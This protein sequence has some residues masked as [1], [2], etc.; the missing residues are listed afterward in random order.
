M[1]EAEVEVVMRSTSSVGKAAFDAA[2]EDT[3]AADAAAARLQ[4]VARGRAV[5]TQ[6]AAAK[7]EAAM[8]MASSRLEEED[9]GG[10][11]GGEGMRMKRGIL[12]RSG[13]D[14]GG[15]GDSGT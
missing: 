15:G 4:S 5:R 8:A 10:G 13:G 6:T 1:C 9:G 11:G 14:G 7:K 12:A 2:L 3:E